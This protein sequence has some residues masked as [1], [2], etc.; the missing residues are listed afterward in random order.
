M[1]GLMG[2]G[3]KR[4]ATTVDAKDPG[5]ETLGVSAKTYRR[6]TPPRQSSTLHRGVVSKRVF[7]SMDDHMWKLTYKWANYSHQNKPKT[8]IIHR[9]YGQFNP[10]RLDRWVFGDRDSGAYLPKF[11]WTNIVRHYMVSGTASPDDP[12][13]AQYW[14]DR[15]RRSTPPLAGPSWIS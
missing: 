11:A 5:G 8:W 10:A 15:H 9:Y 6:A 1:H 3:W 13:L 12:A 14:A 2:G 4:G 7:T